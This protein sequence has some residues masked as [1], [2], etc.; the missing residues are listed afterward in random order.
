MVASR[1]RKSWSVFPCRK[2]KICWSCSCWEG[3]FHG[4]AKPGVCL[5]WSCL[6]VSG[7]FVGVSVLE[8]LPWT[9]FCLCPWCPLLSLFESDP[10]LLLIHVILLLWYGLALSEKSSSCRVLSPWVINILCG[11]Y[12]KQLLCSRETFISDV[13]KLFKNLYQHFK[14]NCLLLLYEIQLSYGIPGLF[15]LFLVFFM[16]QSFFQIFRGVLEDRSLIFKCVNEMWALSRFA[17]SSDWWEN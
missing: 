14:H 5:T 7:H 17:F 6:Q 2:V 10:L 13:L 1:K 3:K 12:D 8:L 4:R 15:Y 11:G 9:C 16:F